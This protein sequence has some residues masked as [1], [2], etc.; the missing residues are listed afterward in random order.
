MSQN[1]K[2]TFIKIIL[3][4]LDYLKIFDIEIKE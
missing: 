1:I 3:I 2:D 4:G